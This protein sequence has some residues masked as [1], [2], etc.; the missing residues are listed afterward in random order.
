MN[1]YKVRYTANVLMTV[2]IE[3]KNE[4]HA[5][6]LVERGEHEN[7]KELDCWNLVVDSVEEK[8]E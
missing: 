7:P 8:Y 3:A 1:K 4:E 5:K 2:E 6:Q